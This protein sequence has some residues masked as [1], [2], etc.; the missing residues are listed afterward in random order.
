MDLIEPYVLDANI[1]VNVTEFD[2]VI[3]TLYFI[4]VNAFYPTKI[5]IILTGN[6]FI[7]ILELIYAKTNHQD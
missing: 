5:T 1:S 6:S 7:L 2:L 3:H 4:C